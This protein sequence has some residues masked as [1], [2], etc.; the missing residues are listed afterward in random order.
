MGQDGNFKGDNVTFVIIDGNSIRR[1]ENL[2]VTS[3]ISTSN[4]G[5]MCQQ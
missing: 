4:K 5:L 3:V 2:S 1:E